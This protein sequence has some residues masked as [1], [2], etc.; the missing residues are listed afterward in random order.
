MF[1]APPPCLQHPRRRHAELPAAVA[2][3]CAD[4]EA[5]LDASAARV[6]L[7]GARSPAAAGGVDAAS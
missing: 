5:A 1:L 4:A 2:R 3:F 7:F 6:A